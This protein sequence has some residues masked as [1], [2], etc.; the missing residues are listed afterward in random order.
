MPRPRFDKSAGWFALGGVCAA[1]IVLW[2]VVL[3]WV[4]TW[5]SMASRIERNAARG[6]DP[7]VKFYSELESFSSR[8]AEFRGREGSEFAIV[9]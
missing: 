8:E 1:V 7:S 4:A 9:R 6:I 5:P 3:P 2:G